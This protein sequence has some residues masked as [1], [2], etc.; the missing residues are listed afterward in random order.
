MPIAGGCGGVEGLEGWTLYMLRAHWGVL[1]HWQC[2]QSGRLGACSVPL[3]FQLPGE[4]AASRHQIPLA[5]ARLTAG[6]RATG[7]KV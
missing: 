4:G 2:A 3:C 7:T 6:P 5:V 1:G